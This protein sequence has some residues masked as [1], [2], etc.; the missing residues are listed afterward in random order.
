VRH[1]DQALDLLVAGIGERE[2][3]PIGVALSR[4]HVHAPN[5]PIGSGRGRNQQA[6]GFGAMALDGIGQVDRLR[7]GADIN[8][9]DRARG[10]QRR[11]DRDERRG[12]KGA[13]EMQPTSS[14]PYPCRPLPQSYASQL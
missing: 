12:H 14:Q 2:H 7:V 1:D 4:A 8:S 11:H 6:V 13:D 10:R 3:G 5:D 9:L